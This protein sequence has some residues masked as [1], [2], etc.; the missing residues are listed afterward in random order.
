MYPEWDFAAICESGDRSFSLA[1]LDALLDPLLSEDL[2]R[3]VIYAL[4]ELDDPRC[5]LPLTATAEDPTSLPTVRARALRV[6]GGSLTHPTG[7]DLRRWWSSE[8]ELLQRAA[9]EL[10]DRTEADIVAVA[11]TDPKWEAAA[12]ASTLFGF[13]EPEWQQKKVA[14]LS[15][16]DPTVVVAAA[17]C[18]FWDEPNI[19]EEPLLHVLAN[20][21]AEAAAEAASTLAYYPS[22]RVVAALRA[23]GFPQVLRDRGTPDPSDGVLDSFRW[24]LSEPEP[25]A[26]RMRTWMGSIADVAQPFEPEPGPSLE[27]ES[28][29]V[30]AQAPQPVRVAW[31][32]KLSAR[33]NNPNEPIH[34]LVDDLRRLDSDAVAAEERLGIA[35]LLCRHPDA[36]LRERGAILAA[37]WG[38]ADPLLELLDDPSVS[39]RKTA[40]YNA[41]DLPQNAMVAERMLELLESGTI[42]STRGREALRTWVRHVD[43]QVAMK[44]L[45]RFARD[46]RCESIAVGAVEELATLQD[47]VDALS[48]LSD[49]LRREPLVTWAMHVTLLDAYARVGIDPGNIEHLRS[50]DNVWLATAIAKV[51]VAR[52]PPA[53]AQRNGTA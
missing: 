21:S 16:P 47:P 17:R 7:V 34:K 14:L 50:V 41:H 35:S 6:L 26:S 4:I 42:A 44:R 25:V 45:I 53:D 8:D 43:Q 36:E 24:A 33:V 19:A 18:L 29:R 32:D 27:A 20:G 40:A 39:V 2:E 46:D 37:V 23:F 28:V 15:S 13:Q 5:L 22:R 31:S 49:L 9:L 38:F 10:M 1:L 3:E 48:R 12:V 51:D 30:V 52:E 11:F